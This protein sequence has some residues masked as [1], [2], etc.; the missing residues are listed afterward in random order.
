M[1]MNI[2]QRFPLDS[3]WT[4]VQSTLEQPCLHFVLDIM[5]NYGIEATKLQK[6]E[7]KI[8]KT[9]KKQ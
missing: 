1:N 9:E 7:I 2:F 4:L 5:G 6:Y 8:Q 3:F